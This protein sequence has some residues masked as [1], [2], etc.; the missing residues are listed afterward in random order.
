MR[1]YILGAKI[2]NATEFLFHCKIRS[3]GKRE[4]KSHDTQFSTVKGKLKINCEECGT[5]MSE[6]QI[7][8]TVRTGSEHN[9]EK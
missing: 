5:P 9:A 2:L 8:S 6:E 1:N 4:R 7:T 3:V